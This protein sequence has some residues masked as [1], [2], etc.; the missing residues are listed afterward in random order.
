M[1]QWPRACVASRASSRHER[2]ITRLPQV[3]QLRLYLRPAA[4]RVAT[5]E[6]WEEE[7]PPF[8]VEFNS[9]GQ[10]V[11]LM[12]KFQAYLARV[13][14]QK[15]SLKRI[16]LPAVT[17]AELGLGGGCEAAVTLSDDR[18]ITEVISLIDLKTADPRTRRR[19]EDRAE[20]LMRLDEDTLLVTVKEEKE[21]GKPPA[22]NTPV[23]MEV[24]V[25]K[26]LETV[27]FKTS[28][29]EGGSR[30]TPTSSFKAKD[31]KLPRP[32][33]GRSS[34]CPN[35]P[36]TKPP[37]ELTTNKVTPAG[38]KAAG[39]KARSQDA[40]TEVEKGAYIDSSP[41][42]SPRK[43]VAPRS[44]GARTEV[45]KGAY[46]D[47]SPEVSP[48]KPAPRS[49][50]EREDSP[51]SSPQPTRPPAKMM[52]TK[53]KPLKPHEITTRDPLYSCEAVGDE[54]TRQN[55]AG[56]FVLAPP[57]LWPDT[58]MPESGGFI[59]K[60]AKVSRG[61]V[62]INFSDGKGRCSWADV[63]STFKPLTPAL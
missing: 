47:S 55:A 58:A 9:K 56:R 50:V 37:R 20:W 25:T 22:T 24:L 5:T 33:L 7:L 42:V 18:A 59:G 61:T 54:L 46:I 26:V 38:V 17:Q 30:S 57:S 4:I 43:P 28:Q 1:S 41:E 36:A 21:E 34:L 49:Q 60:I 52:Q 15:K 16:Q 2:L 44:Q 51:A 40:R 23:D 11:T 19:A 14:N 53:L 27:A 8:E 45:E 62:D 13:R 32:P 29:G 3:P 12:D 6:Q 39:G 10:Q 63:V 48:E 31:R 35:Q